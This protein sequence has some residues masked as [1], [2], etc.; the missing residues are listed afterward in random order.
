[1]SSVAWC[2]RLAQPFGER[3]AGREVTAGAAAGDEEMAHVLDRFSSFSKVIR[4][5]FRR[6]LRAWSGI[7]RAMRRDPKCAGC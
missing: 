2:P 1:M 6:E 4:P 3:D 7:F 5:A